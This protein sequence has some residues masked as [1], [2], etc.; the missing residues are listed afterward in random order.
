MRKVEILLFIV[1][2][3]SW[4]V[5]NI[6]GLID[7]DGLVIT[8]GL[9][10]AIMYLIANYWINPP[11][12][13]N[14]RKTII[15]VLYGIASSCL[16]FL[17][18]LKIFFLIGT[19][20]MAVLAIISLTVIFVLDALINGTRN[21]ALNKWTTGRILVITFIVITLYLIPESSRVK[22]T[23]RKYP[24]FLEYYSN[25]KNSMEFYKIYNAYFEE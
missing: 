6:I 18:L 3:L 15:T 24:E 4:T 8:F 12:T 10:V 25:N 19:D 13:K 21:L 22:F 2:L 9:C 17:L 14:P 11:S 23:Y 20:E 7:Y 16:T 1:F 5:R